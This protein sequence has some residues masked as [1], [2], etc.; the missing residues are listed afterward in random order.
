MVRDRESLSDLLELREDVS[1]LR[2]VD[3]Q[4]FHL[5][6]RGVEERVPC[7][8]VLCVLVAVAA[9]LGEE[10]LDGGDGGGWFWDRSGGVGACQ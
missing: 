3:S 1:A 4:F 9:N 8:E 5:C 10:G 7:W 2:D 6:R